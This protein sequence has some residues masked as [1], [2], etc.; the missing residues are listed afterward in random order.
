[1][2]GVQTC[3]L[4][5]YVPGVG[6]IACSMVDA[7]NACVFVRAADVG[8]TGTEMPEALEQNLAVMK[9]LGAIRLAAS[10]A[11]G[12]SKNIEEA[13]R[14]PSVP[15]IGV[16][17]APRDAPSLSGDPIQANQADVTGRMLSNGQVHRALPLTCT[18]CLAIAAR[19]Q[20]SVVYEAT[21]ET[22]DPESDLRI[23]MPSGV[24]TVAAIVKQVDGKWYAEKGAVYR[25]QRRMFEGTVLVRASCT[26]GLQ[27]VNKQVRRAA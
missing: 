27:T 9:K 20:G 17:S 3:A 24:L 14:K 5:I 7:A 18:V 23:A 2:T 21:R 26:P 13:A 6:R 11:M 10:V 15:F 16:V 22:P 4:P 1:M 25:T 12:I 8:L 19:I